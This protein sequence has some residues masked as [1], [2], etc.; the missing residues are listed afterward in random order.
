M[1]SEDSD[2]LVATT[3]VVVHRLWNS[4]FAVDLVVDTLIRGYEGFSD[5]ERLKLLRQLRQRVRF[6]RDVL[7]DL[8]R[9]F[10]VDVTGA[11]EVTGRVPDALDLRIDSARARDRFIELERQNA[12]AR[13]R[14]ALLA[15]QTAE[16]RRDGQFLHDLLA[17]LAGL[18]GTEGS[19]VIDERDPRLVSLREAL[20]VL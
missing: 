16:L 3:S 18:I 1:V 13:D 12:V 11:I 19:V 2:D 6:N 4:I 20:R 9:M 15:D 8:L 10:P 7:T 17:D 14:A 5:R